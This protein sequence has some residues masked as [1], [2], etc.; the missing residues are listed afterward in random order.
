MTRQKLNQFFIDNKDELKDKIIFIHND[1]WSF[2]SKDLSFVV[3]LKNAE[4]AIWG[5]AA[6][7]FENDLLPIIYGVSFF[8]IG[9][10]E[11]LRKFFGY[12]KKPCIIFN[13]GA[14]GYDRYGWEHAFK[15]N[16][17]LKI[18]KSLKFKTFNPKYKFN[19]IKNLEDEYLFYKI[20]NWKN[21]YFFNYE[22][23]NYY[24]RLDKDQKGIK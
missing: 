3:D 9:R 14:Y 8:E 7:A 6:G 24:I 15:N 16:D 19:F 17:D 1:L 12:N 5:F 23:I 10:L 22:N 21:E 13:A 2:N 20:L 4:S 11:Q 18:M